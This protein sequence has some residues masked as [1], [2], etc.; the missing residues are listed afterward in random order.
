MEN[1]TSTPFEPF[2][3]LAGG[4]LIGSSVVLLLLTLGRI[5]GI[6]GIAAGAM[7]E[8]GVERYWRLA[9]LIGVVLSAVFYI[10]FTGG[11]QVQTQMSSAWL[12]VAGLLVGFGTRLGSGCTSGHGVA[13]LSRLSPRSIVATLTFMGAAVLT[14]T[15]I[16]HL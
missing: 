4:L 10:G 6:S 11:M 15:I 7:T 5:A 3:G 8:R 2:A 13:G 12:V 9:F 1:W 16:R 14:T